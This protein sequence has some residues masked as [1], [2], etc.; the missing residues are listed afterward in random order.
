[1]EGSRFGNLAAVIP[2]AACGVTQAAGPSFETLYNFDGSD[3]A[4]PVGRLA[5][6]PDGV[7]YGATYG[8][9]SNGW[10][11][12][13][14]L[15][16][17]S[18]PG[19]EW[20][21]AVLN[22]FTGGDDGSQPGAGVIID[23]AGTLYGTTTFGGVY[24][25]GVVFSLTPPASPGGAWTETV[26][27]HFTGG[28]DGADPNG[29]LVRTSNGIRFGTTSYGGENLSQ[30]VA[31]ALIPP[32][33]PGGAWTESVLH[34]FGGTGDGRQPFSSLIESDGVFYGTTVL[35][36]ASSSPGGL[37][38]Q[39]TVFSLARQLLVAARGPRLFCTV[40]AAAVT[41]AAPAEAWRLVLKECSMVRPVRQDLMMWAQRFR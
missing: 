22:S 20:T 37:F 14:S 1:M 25:Y 9:G 41:E 34:S 15:T 4:G 36:G 5:R 38:G 11:S 28:D 23:L 30:G 27:H 7:L 6:G 13:F 24:G 17:P 16:P 26:L 18:S 21:Q 31:F 10:G 32:S 19:G 2:L 33:P 12:V 39:G 3:G 8:G 29:S 35:G 40:L